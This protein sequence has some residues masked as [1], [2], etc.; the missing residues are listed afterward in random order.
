[1]ATL[2]TLEWTGKILAVAAP[3][4]TFLWW[5]F[6]TLHRYFHLQAEHAD[7]QKTLTAER[8]A[9]AKDVDA[10]RRE[11]DQLRHQFEAK[12][13]AFDE[14]RHNY[15]A[16]E[17]A[18]AA[19]KSQPG[20]ALPGL[21]LS[22]DAAVKL[23]QDLQKDLTHRSDDL[24]R[25]TVRLAR[26]DEQFRTAEQHRDTTAAERD[27]LH[28]Q[29]AEQRTISDQLSQEMERRVEELLRVA[30]DVRDRLKRAD[31]LRQKETS[32]VDQLTAELAETHRLL[33]ESEERFAALMTRLDGRL[34]LRPAVNPP[35]FR[36]LTDRRTVV[37]S[38]LNLKGGVGKTTITANLAATLGGQG[39]RVLMLDLDYQRSLSMLLLGEKDRELLHLQ[40]RCV[41]HLLRADG[42]TLER[43]LHFATP[44][45]DEATGC[46]IVTNSDVR[47]GE[48]ADSLEETENRLM[49]DWLVNPAGGDVR[50]F[51]R[52][53]L[54][55]P[56]LRE[57]F[58]LVLL[59]CPPRLTTACVN[60]VAAS[61]FVLIPVVPDAVSTRAVENLL[62][63]LARLR[64]VVCPDLALLGIVPNMVRTHAGALIQPH[65]AALV[66]LNELVGTG[67]VWPEPVPV[68]ESVVP[69]S[70]AFVKTAA[71]LDAAGSLRL[72][73]RDAKVAEAFR[74]LAEELGQEI[75]HHASEHAPTVPPK[76]GP[77][78]EGR[79]RSGAH[80]S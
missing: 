1:M 27:A 51:L 62:R 53:A 26:L 76:P 7:L 39:K 48:A 71:M 9:H 63:A 30:D 34:W 55:E 66:S 11:R 47:D 60:A 10:L 64:G 3:V 61:D 35:P 20:S 73:L 37:L 54:H 42:C 78:P 28:R 75:E 38:V 41:Q 70:S 40:R 44:V 29:L 4:L 49:A 12:A 74:S 32:R 18:H 65:D 16:L 69:D 15:T 2:E 43:L 72:A 17:A 46:D 79:R 13:S 8:A 33:D 36:P 50:F 14:L 22:G 24:H 52:R 21:G 67:R 19:A 56:G 31:D 45:G 80:G 5:M 23:I 77:R 68:L 57:R 6:R 25:T 58:D 59:D